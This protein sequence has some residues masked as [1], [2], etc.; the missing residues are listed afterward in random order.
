MLLLTFIENHLFHL[1]FK[2]NSSCAE[3]ETK[4]VEIFWMIQEAIARLSVKK[5]RSTLIF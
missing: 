4:R 3:L 5:F 1:A 2:A